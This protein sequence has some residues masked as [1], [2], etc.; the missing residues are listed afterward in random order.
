MR[1]TNQMTA[2]TVTAQLS[3]QTEQ[4]A[5]TQEKIITGKRINRVSD[6]PAGMSRVLS[7]RQTISNL[8][9]YNKNISNGKLHIDTVDNAFLP[10]NLGHI[11]EHQL[12][13]VCKRGKNAHLG[14]HL[15]GA[16]LHQLSY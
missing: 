2:N 8:E 1:V 14:A 5:K 3:R 7:Y 16:Y 12:A 15:V 4:M 13:V 9:Q 11:L 6:D 10:Q